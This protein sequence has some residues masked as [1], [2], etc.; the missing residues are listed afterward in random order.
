MRHVRPARIDIEGLYNSYGVYEILDPLYLVNSGS[1]FGVTEARAYIDED[2]AEK[3][4]SDAYASF[5]AP[6]FSLDSVLGQFT[7]NEDVQPMRVVVGEDNL[8]DF[9]EGAGGLKATVTDTT[10]RRPGGTGAGN[11]EDIV[12]AAL[13]AAGGTYTVL[14]DDATHKF[15][16]TQIAPAT[17][18]QIELAV[19]A[20]NRDRSGWRRLGFDGDASKTGALNYTSDAAIFTDVDAQH[21][22]RLTVTGYKDDVAGTYTGSA[23]ATIQKPGGSVASLG[24]ARCSASQPIRSS[25]DEVAAVRTGA[26]NLSVYLGAIGDER[27]EFGQIVEWIENS[28]GVELLFDGDRF[29]L[30]KRDNS[31]PA[32]ILTIYDRDVIGTPEWWY[33]DEDLGEH[34][35]ARRD[36]RPFAG[37][38]QER[39][40]QREPLQPTLAVLCA[41]AKTRLGRDKGK[42]FRTYLGGGA[43]TSTS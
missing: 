21:I 6:V 31:V 26:D 17:T 18:Y 16:V 11:F 9:N 35:P 8:Y 24:R 42:T 43:H 22:I 33:D 4:L 3:E 15:T 36:P 7:V 1:G 38:A 13:D 34:H 32:G 28:N 5:G 12:K 10:H 27:H 25:R 19:A 14:Y 40:R 29:M 41:S 2:S 30:R 37:A 20:A 39:H 23:G